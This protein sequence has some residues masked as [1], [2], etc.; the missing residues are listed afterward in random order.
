MEKVFED[1]MN[2]WATNSLLWLIVIK[3]FVI[4]FVGFFRSIAQ[5]KQP[6][7]LWNQKEFLSRLISTGNSFA[8]LLTPLFAIFGFLYNL[9]AWFIY[10]ITTIFDGLIWL[11]LWIWKWFVFVCVWVFHNV[12]DPGFFFVVKIIWRYLFVWTWYFIRTA[13]EHLRVRFPFRV[14]LTAYIGSAIAGFVILLCIIFM[15]EL[16]PVGVIIGI[17]V[18]TFFASRILAELYPEYEKSWALIIL[19][20]TLTWFLLTIGLVLMIAIVNLIIYGSFLQ[21]TLFGI[22]MGLTSYMGLGVLFFLILFTFSESMLPA[23]IYHYEGKITEIKFIGE[24]GKN[25]LKYIFSVPFTIFPLILLILIPAVIT[26][27]IYSGSERAKELTLKKSSASISDNL[28]KKDLQMKSWLDTASYTPVLDKEIES[29][30]FK[31]AKKQQRLAEI[32]LLSE[33]F[34][35][36]LLEGAN[37]FIS[38]EHLLSGITEMEESIRNI[39]SKILDTENHINQETETLL[40]LDSLK[41]LILPNGITARRAAVMSGN[42]KKFGVPSSAGTNYYLWKVLEG[43]QGKEIDKKQTR[44]NL[45][46]FPADKVGEFTLTVIPVNA[47]GKNLSQEMSIGFTVEPRPKPTII[48]GPFGPTEVCS[49]TRASFTASDG[50]NDYQFYFPT[51]VTVVKQTGNTVQVTWGNTAGGVSYT[52]SD[53]DG[54]KLTSKKLYVKANSR[55]G[56][57]TSSEAITADITDPELPEEPFVFCTMEEIN[58]AIN[59]HVQS[60]N[61]LESILMQLLN[62]KAQQ[63]AEKYA[64]AS[65]VTVNRWFNIKYSVGLVFLA[66]AFASLLALVMMFVMV[67]LTRYHFFLYSFKQEGEF[68][69]VDR[70]HDYH[71]KNPNQPLL[72]LILFPLFL[73]VVMMV[74]KLSFVSPITEFVMGL[75]KW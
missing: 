42:S 6:S 22:D 58:A 26:W 48:P 32:D 21:I 38:S 54:R 51:D 36:L 10:G 68:Y 34:T 66:L 61:T 8:A 16:L 57:N 41:D 46:F 9:I 30:A 67:Y 70:Y 19:K 60:R 18:T 29:K 72:G 3:V 44:D 55:P 47:C 23:H 20:K 45:L 11:I 65:T 5:N 63:V 59:D 24:I 33:P 28:V 39:D 27:G 75:F 52:A 49:G 15:R 12:I 37:D 7:Y 13:F 71:R 50:Y 14:Y 2:F 56:D 31:I 73:L 53:R 25:F 35:T 40:I 69:I 1:I 4:A 62:Q 64:L 43:S 74:A 17:I